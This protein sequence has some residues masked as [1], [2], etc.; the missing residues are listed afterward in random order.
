MAKLFSD[1]T[2]DIRRHATVFQA[3]IDVAD[4][5]EEIGSLDNAIKERKATIASMDA[6]LATLA[7]A[8]AKEKEE[9]KALTGKKA[10]HLT[11]I[12][13]MLATAEAKAAEIIAAAQ[14]QGADIVATADKSADNIVADAEGRA[15]LFDERVAA[16]QAQLAALDAEI[17]EKSTERT[18]LQKAI[19]A[20]KSKFA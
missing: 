18:K 13:S 1:I 16:A 11:R 17:A 9:I 2:K 20:I 7:S 4:A 10:E 19:D 8:S 6:E 14:K 12:D 15:K 3:V 5:L